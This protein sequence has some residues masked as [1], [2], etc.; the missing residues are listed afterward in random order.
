MGKVPGILEIPLWKRQTGRAFPMLTLMPL[1]RNLVRTLGTLDGRAGV[2]ILN[3]TTS[4]TATAD[5]SGKVI[6]L[7]TV[8][9]GGDG[10]GK[11][12]VTRGGHKGSPFQSQL[13]C[14]APLRN[15]NVQ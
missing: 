12:H 14:F 2:T 10:T 9:L 7:G 13:S 11:P 15:C 6:V 4:F 5:G 3:H 8:V 1:C